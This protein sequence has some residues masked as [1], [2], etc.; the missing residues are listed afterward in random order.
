M[1]L[2]AA[3][4]LPYDSG[5][6]PV[7]APRR[8]KA[9][10]RKAF[11]IALVVAAVLGAALGAGPARRSYHRATLQRALARLADV[12]ATQPTGSARL[13]ISSAPRHVNMR[14]GTGDSKPLELYAAAL[15]VLQRAKQVDSRL[16]LQAAGV[17]H[18]YLADYASAVRE[19]EKAAGASPSAAAWND[20]AAARLEGS[21]AGSTSLDVVAALVAVEKALSADPLLP[22]ALYNR[23]V[24]LERMGLHRLAL[25]AWRPALIAESDAGWRSIIGKHI[26]RIPPE[27]DESVAPKVLT[28]LRP[29]EAGEVRE[30]VDRFPEIARRYAENLFPVQWAASVSRGESAVAEEKLRLARALAIALRDRSGETLAADAVATIDAATASGSADRVLALASAYSV[31]GRGR[32]L[33]GAHDYAAAEIQLGD[34]ADRFAHFKNPMADVARYYLATAILEQNRLDEA[35]ARYAA[36]ARGTSSVRGY[37]AFD[38]Q[39]GWQIARTEGLRGHWDAAL[40]AAEAAADGFRALGERQ[41]TGF[42][43]NMRAEIYDYLGQPE[44]AWK[45]RFVAFD[46][47]SAAANSEQLQVSLGAAA[48]ELIRRRDLPAAVALLDLEIAETGGMKDPFLL[49]D[50]LAR[51]A[52]AK[53][54]GGDST[55]ALQDVASAQAAAQRVKDAQQ[56]AQATATIDVAAGYAAAGRNRAESIRRFTNAIDFYQRTSRSILLPELYLERGRVRLAL[57]LEGEA[58]ADFNSGI[59]RLEE[60]RATLSDFEL[61]STVADVGEDLFIEAVRL[62]VRRKDVATA[63][64]LAERSRGRTLVRRLAAGDVPAPV[65]VDSGSRVVEFMIL[66]EKLIVFT[67]DRELRMRELDVGRGELEQL[68]GSYTARIVDGAPAEQVQSAAAEL[69]DVLLRPLGSVTEGV[70]TLVFAPSGILERVPWAA[71]YDRQQQRYVVED[72]SVAST[73]S[74]TLYALMAARDASRAH[75]AMVVGNPRIAPAFV[76]LPVLRGAE[77]EARTIAGHYPRHTLLLGAEATVERVRRAAETCEVLHFASHAVSSEASDDQS[78]LVLAPDEKAGDSGMLYSRDVANLNLHHVSLVVLAACGTIRGPTV[79][80]DG[81]PSIGR[82]FLAAGAKAVIGTLW[83]LDDDRSAALFARIPRDVSLGKPV[84]EAIRDSQIE[85]IRSGDPAYAHPSVWG[86]LT[87]IGGT[88]QSM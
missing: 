5:A 30:A 9:Q 47:L 56:R 70:A 61:H 3:V 64:R 72:V 50:A 19:L 14:S 78:F 60:Q 6:V 31:Y 42:M 71:L 81:M 17:A 43:E 33:L 75:C 86:G 48:R 59:D 40:D 16:S 57:G 76:D 68:V 2:S 15:P 74:V 54:A 29:E 67:V 51:R 38:A 84:V 28:E 79:H 22:P 82:S 73:P 1:A 65:S 46:L 18:Y 20:L 80:I 37:R 7:T 88:R 36:L 34:A 13:S 77:Q 83:N 23:A 4:N 85:A 52:R 26:D 69:Y 39:L 63:Y 8:M 11:T 25:A 53:A 55:G 10:T 58:L 66:P 41:N 49:S 32:A 27:V 62:A 44:R 35:A 45:H 21:R 87:L 24:I 12:A